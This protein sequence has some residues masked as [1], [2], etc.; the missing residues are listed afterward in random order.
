MRK[1]DGWKYRSFKKSPTCYDQRL[2]HSSNAG[3]VGGFWHTAKSLINIT[4]SLAFAETVEM[5]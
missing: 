4:F 5:F 2:G 1:E 3:F